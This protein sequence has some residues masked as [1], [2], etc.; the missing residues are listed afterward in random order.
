MSPVPI[1]TPGWRETKGSKVPCLRKQRDGR[2]LNPGPPDPEFELLTTQPHTPAQRHS[3]LFIWATQISSYNLFIHKSVA[4]NLYVYVPSSPSLIPW[5]LIWPRAQT[6]GIPSTLQSST[7]LT[8]ALTNPYL[9]GIHLNLICVSKTL[10]WSSLNKILI[11][12]YLLSFL[13]NAYST[14]PSKQYLYLKM[15]PK[16]SVSVTRNKYLQAGSLVFP[17]DIFYH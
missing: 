12:N 8:A 13:W 17:T 15:I 10:R 6:H 11:L 1:Y 16:E 5:V 14:N 7:L 2:G 3:Y 4:E 9:W